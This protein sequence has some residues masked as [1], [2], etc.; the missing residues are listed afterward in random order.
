MNR[1]TFVA[2]TLAM[3]ATIA[4][5]RARAAAADTEANVIDDLVT[6]NHVLAHE[7]VVDGFGHVSVRDPQNANHYRLARSMAPALVTAADIMTYD[8]DSNALD[9]NGR[10]SYAERFIHGAIYKARPDVMSI[11]HAHTPAV[12][13]FGA[14]P[15]VRLQPVF[16]LGAFLGAGV[17]VFEIRDAGGSATDMLVSSQPFGDA[18]ARRLGTANVALMRGHGMVAVAGSIPEA[19]FRAYYTGQDAQ[20]QADAMRLGSPTYLSADEARRATQTQAGLV[21]RA[22]DLWKRALAPR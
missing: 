19:V 13:P 20:L 11:V 8:L 9:A 17:P 15:A 21:S 16:H 18:L 14:V 7:N 22:W 10:T 4:S 2:A 12:I 5:P 6:A 1:V 3:T